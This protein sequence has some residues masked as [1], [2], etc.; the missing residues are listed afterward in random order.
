MNSDSENMA[1]AIIDGASVD[2]L[3]DD[4]IDGVAVGVFVGGDDFR[5][6]VAVHVAAEDGFDDIGVGDKR[7]INGERMRI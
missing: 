5:I 6:V 7:V 2:I 4:G 1:G 3:R